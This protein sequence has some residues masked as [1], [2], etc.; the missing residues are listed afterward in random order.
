V[1]TQQLSYPVGADLQPRE[2]LEIGGQA[3]TRPASEGETQLLR[4]GLDGPNQERQ[5]V[6][7]H[8]RRTTG[9]GGI[10]QPLKPQGAPPSAPPVHRARR[11]A[12]GLGD[13]GGALP[14]CAPKNDGRPQRNARLALLPQGSQEPLPLGRRHLQSELGPGHFAALLNGGRRSYP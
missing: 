14:L 1:A 12:Q 8:T 11:H 10:G 3:R 6:S 5:E 7:V 2:R 9:A 13:T 4:I